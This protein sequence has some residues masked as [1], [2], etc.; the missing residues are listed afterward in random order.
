MRHY[1]RLAHRTRGALVQE[2]VRGH[3][4]HHHVAWR[5]GALVAETCLSRSSAVDPGAPNP[6]PERIAT[7]VPVRE[8]S[9]ALLAA[10]GW[11]GAA[12][13]KYGRRPDGTLIFLG[14]VPRWG[15]AQPSRPLRGATA[16][17]SWL[18]DPLPAI[19]GW[20][21]RFREKEIHADRGRPRL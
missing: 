13:I 1:C 16:F 3:R 9:E 18:V 6:L 15:W 19:F 4:L 5:D 8:A 10:L 12:E 21:R 17:P 14:F 20:C 7:P 2:R 11:E